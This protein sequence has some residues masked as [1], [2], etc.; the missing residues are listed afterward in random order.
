MQGGIDQ[1]SC[2][3]RYGVE[4]RTGKQYQIDECS[5]T[6]AEHPIS[7]D[8]FPRGGFD[9]EHG[10]SLYADCGNTCEMVGIVIVNSIACFGLYR[11][12]P[13][14]QRE[15]GRGEDEIPAHLRPRVNNCLRIPRLPMNGTGSKQKPSRISP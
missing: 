14:S 8:D 4:K 11:R 2:A 10:I 3:F 1:P 13:F 6:G 9:I 5:Q 15:K 12:V 7:N